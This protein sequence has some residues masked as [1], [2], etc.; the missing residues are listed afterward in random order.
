MVKQDVDGFDINMSAE[1][2]TE[3]RI[4]SYKYHFILIIAFFYKG[5][6]EKPYCTWN[7]CHRFLNKNIDYN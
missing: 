6:F 2:C 4:Y 1:T 5:P 7:S 3:I